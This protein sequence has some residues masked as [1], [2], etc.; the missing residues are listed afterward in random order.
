[1]SEKINILSEVRIGVF[2]GSPVRLTCEAS[3][4]SRLSAN[5]RNMSRRG[6]V[7]WQV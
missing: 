1:M 7:G 5:L 3:G 2:S 4:G 6:A